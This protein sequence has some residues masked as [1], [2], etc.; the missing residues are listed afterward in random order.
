[1]QFAGAIDA[2]ALAREKVRFW[3]EVPVPARRM[4]RT[5]SSLGA[6]PVVQLHAGGLK[7]GELGARAR[8]NGL[9]LQDAETRSLQSGLAQAV[10]RLEGP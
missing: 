5:F 2:E 1:V 8:Q 3:P 9:N 10:L 7:V 4:V 6:A